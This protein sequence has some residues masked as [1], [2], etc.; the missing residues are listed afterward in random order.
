MGTVLAMIR[1]SV[2]G[3]V[4][5]W[6]SETEVDA[7]PRQQRLILAL[8]LAAAGKPVDVTELIELLWADRPP[9]SAV[10]VVH[11]Y[12]GMLRRLLE[13]GLPS[14]SS[15]R[16]LL[17]H[18][19]GYRLAADETTLDLLAARRLAADGRRLADQ[20]DLVTAV[21]TYAQALDLWKGPCGTGLEPMARIHPAFVAIDREA[22]A[23]AREAADL[24]LRCGQAGTILPALRHAVAREPFDEALQARMLL[25]LAADG[26]QAEALTTYTGLHRRLADELGIDPGPE[27]MAAHQQVL[28]W[29]GERAIPS[30]P[31]TV[32]VPPAQLPPDLPF[33][34]GRRAELALL[35]DRLP[36]PDGAAVTI[37]VDGMPGVGKSALAVH[38]AHQVS[39]RFPDGQLFLNLRGFDPSGTP[40]THAEALRTLLSGLGMPYER[41]PAE[42]DAQVGLYRSLL[43]GRRMLVML[44]NARDAEQAKPLLPAMRGCAA[45]VTSRNR[46]TGLAIQGAA[47]L[48]V[49]LPPIEDARQDLQLRIGQTRA[50]AEP[51]ALDA[52]IDCCARLPLA[53]AVVGARA[54]VNPAFS[55]A[56]IAGELRAA[57]NSLEALSGD[58]TVS[59]VRGVFSWSYRALSPEAARLFRLL[60]LAVGPDVSLV[61]AASLTGVTLRPARESAGELTRS[62]LLIE[63]LP[64]RFVLH[65]LLRAYAMELTHDH[66]PASERSAALTRLITHYE[67]TLRAA[68][69]WLDP[70][71][72]PANT[73]ASDDSVIIE[74]AGDHDSAMKILVRISSAVALQMKGFNIQRL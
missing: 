67:H 55:L 47:S 54:R 35:D 42:A 5:V 69:Q 49:G 3:P 58:D 18:G 36:P 38:W 74:T 26:K 1:F 51:A 52:L 4:R 7:G 66:D 23:L 19:S 46:L 20:D 70:E 13:P 34:V 63:H 31:P 9:A 21:S 11:R 29:S 6:R 68:Q 62:R 53:M 33:F 37:A 57:Q 10:N 65:D 41:I 39:T 28:H 73:P 56:S 48:T 32:V 59:D 44:D 45:V 61:A 25:C 43:A 30:T 50:A 15:G 22:S 8:L 71:P 40:V 16:W 17:R 72:A 60:S 27:L 12:V 2:L 64:G 24:A 14:R